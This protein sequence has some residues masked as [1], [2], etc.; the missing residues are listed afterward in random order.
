MIETSVYTLAEKDKDN[1]PAF[2]CVFKEVGSYKAKL[3]GIPDRAEA[4]DT[5]FEFN[6]NV[7]EKYHHNDSGITNDHHDVSG[8]TD[9]HH[10][11]T[12]HTDDHHDD[13][14]NTNGQHDIEETKDN[15][16]LWLYI[17]LAVVG[18]A[19]ISGFVFWCYRKRRGT[20]TISQENLI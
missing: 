11:V 18:V 16:L 3:E 8:N 14:G 2:S 15:S 17:L 4:A 5:V 19:L 9:D 12:G 6:I 10:N 7:E 1:T 20:R 13:S